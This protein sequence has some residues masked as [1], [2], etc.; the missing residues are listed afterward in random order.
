MHRRYLEHD[1]RL[2]PYER[3]R[4]VDGSY[5][6]DP[7][8]QERG[9]VHKSGAELD[10]WAPGQGGPRRDY[11]GLGPRDAHRRDESVLEEVCRALERDS[12]VDATEIE[13]QC[14][15]CEVTLLGTVHDR[16]QKRLAERIVDGVRGVR[17]VHNQLRVRDLARQD[18]SG[19][20]STEST[21]TGTTRDTNR[22][23]SS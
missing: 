19:E 5:R 12:E 17:D 11:S 10:H 13:V 8:E 7:F 3:A 21:V 4:W 23:V 6:P 15:D 20:L 1:A 16:H 22:G 18:S 9:F 14:K 2:A